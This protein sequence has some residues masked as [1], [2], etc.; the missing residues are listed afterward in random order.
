MPP[1]SGIQV[2]HVAGH[3]VTKFPRPFLL[4]IFDGQIKLKGKDK[5]KIAFFYFFYGIPSF[6]FFKKFL[7]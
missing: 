4:P 2:S 7:V 3:F 6:N 5:K 1:L